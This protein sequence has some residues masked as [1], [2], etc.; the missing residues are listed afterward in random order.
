MGR[1]AHQVVP[2]AVLALVIASLAIASAQVASSQ[3]PPERTPGE[4]SKISSVVRRVLTQLQDMA[5]TRQNAGTMAVHSLSI[6]QLIRV[7]EFGQIQVYIRVSETGLEQVAQLESLEVVIEIVNRDH[8]IIQAWVHFDR[9]VD[10]A[11]LDFVRRISPPA[12]AHT[13]TGSVTT[14]GDQILRA[15]LARSL[16]GL[17]GSGVQVGVISDGVDSA[18]TA[19]SSGDLPAGIEIDLFRPGSGDEGTAMLEI[20]HDIASGAA[21]AFSGLGTPSGGGTSLEMIESIRYLANN[22]FDGTG[23]DAIVDDVGFFDEPYF[24]DGPVA[25]EVASAVTTGVIYVSSAGNAAQIHYEAPFHRGAGG[26][27]NF[28]GGDQAMFIKVP[29]GGIAVAFL[30]WNDP[31][32]ASGNNYDLYLCPLS[33]TSLI[34]C[35]SSR[36]VQNGNDDPLE[37]AGVTNVGASAEFINVVIDG[38]LAAQDRQLELF[39]LGATDSEYVVPGGSIFGH[40]AVPGAIAVGA[41]DAADVG[42]DTI[43]PFSSHGPSVVYFPS[44]E[45]RT[46][47]DVTAIDGVSVTGAGGFPTTFFG[48][49]AAAPHVAGVAAL[50]LEAVRSNQPGIGKLQARQAV[51]DAITDTAVD[52]GFVGVDQ[53]YGAGRADALAA[54]QQALG[55]NPTPTPIPTATPTPTPSATPSPSPTP[56]LTSTPTPTPTATPTATQTPLPPTPTATHTPTATPTA[57]IT[58][59]PAP[60]ATPTATPALTATPTSM[61]TAS[62]SPSITPSPTITP[63]PTSTPTETPSAVPSPTATPT[64]QPVGPPIVSWLTIDGGT[65]R[66]AGGKFDFAGTVGQWDASGAIAS[67]SHSFIGGFWGVAAVSTSTGTP[68]PTATAVPT[69]TPMPPPVATPTA[70]PTVT[71]IGTV[72]SATVWGLLTLGL[73]TA[74]IT[75]RRLRRTRPGT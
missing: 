13:R 17:R 14:E 20:I 66:S 28:S 40:P 71:P 19:Q 48:T 59:S 31:F 32:G 67:N 53:V 35:F 27:H 1:F 56:S 64:P 50:V 43:E 18:S 37:V 62:P 49:S 60:T 44:F 47:P 26:F 36:D 42:H 30:Q 11:S 33:A 4:D 54:A 8:K 57:T 41:I 29:A 58:P 10:V 51:Y 68:A 23:A 5:A 72:P 15:D 45:S 25:Q 39:V 61:P 6:P 9:V 38:F 34:E 3:A 55:I 12:Y 22:A 75:L 52:L 7:N 46:K 21:L 65:G 2:L 69:A 70:T 63:T 24:E 73:M 16:H 74:L